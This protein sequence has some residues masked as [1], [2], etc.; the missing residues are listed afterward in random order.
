L[1]EFEA[2]R[3]AINARIRPLR[4]SRGSASSSIFATREV[5]LSPSRRDSPIAI[6]FNRKLIL[7]TKES[8]V[9][10]LAPELSPR[11]SYYP[12]RGGG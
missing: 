11:V 2:K 6:L 5:V 10:H 1:R 7:T 12:I 3:H 9:A 8:D 4:V